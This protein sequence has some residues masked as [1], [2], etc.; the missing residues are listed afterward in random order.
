MRTTATLLLILL[1][2]A[3]LAA[4]D[5]IDFEAFLDGTGTIDM[6]PISD[7]YLPLGVTFSLVESGGETIVGYPLI[8]KTGP[9]RTAFVGCSDDDTPLPGQ[10]VGSSF[11]TNKAPGGEIIGDLL[12]TYH[13]PVSMASGVII[14][15]DCRIDGGP[16]CEQW[17]ITAR[18]S[19]N[20]V[21]GT[22]VIDGP[23]GPENLECVAPQAGPGDGVAFS[24]FFDVAPMTIAAIRITYTG[25]AD[26]VGL[27]FDNFSP[28]SLDADLSVSVSGVS[29]PVSPGDTVAYSA[30][31]TN[32]GP[33][34]AT[35]VVLAGRIPA[36]MQFIDAAVT[37]D[38]SCGCE[39]GVLICEI[40]NL[41]SGSAATVSVVAA[42]EHVVLSNPVAV[43]A[44][45]VD[46]FTTGNSDTLY[47]SVDCV[48]T[49]SPESPESPWT[50]AAWQNSP[51]P[52]N[53]ST[54][55][56]YQVGRAGNVAIRIY[57]LRGRLV[58]TLLDDWVE[59]GRYSAEWDGTSDGSRRV[60]SGVYFY[61]MSV[62]GSEVS[63]KKAVVLK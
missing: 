17:T 26:G 57:D 54:S 62:D 63:S 6:Q 16:P 29:G 30:V 55:I 39:A 13:T 9:P 25:E 15:V 18:D 1:C 40:G 2:G 3:S 48:A 28:A 7:E 12:V 44:N 22:F 20:S 35:G 43:S 8:A 38:G 47:T 33:G 23:P 61:R 4:S 27:A 24:W 10:S 41:P 34:D 5:V 45:E 49:G 14:D 11:I 19:L 31:V 53:P 42:L 50:A 59:P 51:N 32:N 52:F 46:L 60:A 21:I 37:P 56:Q 58:R 36:G